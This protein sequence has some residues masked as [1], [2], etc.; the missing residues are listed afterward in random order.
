MTFHPRSKTAFDGWSYAGS[1]EGK[2][3]SNYEVTR[4]FLTNKITQNQLHSADQTSISYLRNV[5][6]QE[7]MNLIR[8]SIVCIIFVKCISM[9]VKLKL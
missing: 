1:T 3:W 4:S 5:K 7:N 8:Y 2:I 6:T 9:T